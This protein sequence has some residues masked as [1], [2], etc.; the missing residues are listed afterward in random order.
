MIN[1]FFV[2]GEAVKFVDFIVLV[3]LN[4][5]FLLDCGELVE[6][7]ELRDNHLVGDG[8][9]F[10]ILWVAFGNP[11]GPHMLRDKPELTFKP[12]SMHTDMVLESYRFAHYII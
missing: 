8:T 3:L 6:V 5:F 12:N 10:D 2:D 11:E 1:A 9:I 4:Y 7:T